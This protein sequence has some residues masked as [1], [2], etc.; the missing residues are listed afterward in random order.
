[1]CTAWPP[2]GRGP[3]RGGSSGLLD[4]QTLRDV[5]AGLDGHGE[6][7]LGAA[8]GDGADGV[9]AGLERHAGQRRDAG[10]LAVDVDLRVRLGVDA[11]VAGRRRRRDRREAGLLRL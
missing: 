9:L 4:R 6:L 5:L 3:A 1:M 2:A 11:E 10:R 7:L 8:L